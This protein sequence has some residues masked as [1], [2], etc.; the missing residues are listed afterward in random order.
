MYLPNTLPSARY[1]Y[2]AKQLKTDFS[3]MTGSITRKHHRQ[4]ELS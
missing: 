1:I 3:R 4:R 2:M